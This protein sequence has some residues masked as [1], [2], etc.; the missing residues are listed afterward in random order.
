[1]S[2]I[3]DISQLLRTGMPV[4]PGDTEFQPSWV[5]RIE[6]GGPC[7][8]GRVLMSLHTG[9]HVDAP[10]HFQK[11][12]TSIADVDLSLYI[13]EAC[14]IDALNAGSVEAS[15]LQPL[16]AGLP[17]R[18][19]FRTRISPAGQFDPGFSYIATDAAS[20][21][22]RSGVKLVGI[23]TPSVDSAHSEAMETHKILGDAG[24]AI[25]ENLNL[26]DAPAG[27]Y[28]LIALPLKFAGM[29]GSPVRAVLRTMNAEARRGHP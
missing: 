21:L 13:G 28:E 7:N 2:Q 17:P 26:A 20:L 18:V 3:I 19:L 4:W 27:M 29:D 12:G 6:D 10:L 16:T 1:M 5:A 14:V 23:D 24:I 8:V 11:N 9:T 25:L 22:V 15:H